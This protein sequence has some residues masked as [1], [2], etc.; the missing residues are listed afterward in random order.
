MIAKQRSHVSVTATCD[1]EVSIRLGVTTLV[2]VASAS[3]YRSRE[4]SRNDYFAEARYSSSLGRA[5][6][7]MLKATEVVLIKVFFRECSESGRGL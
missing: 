4:S 1:H 5:R 3:E 7:H 6:H 2:N